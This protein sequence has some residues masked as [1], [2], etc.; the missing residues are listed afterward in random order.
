MVIGIV[1]KF[2]IFV[3]NPAKAD[4]T[5]KSKAELKAERR[6]KQEAQRA[7][8]A[9]PAAPEAKQSAAPKAAQAKRIPDQIQ[10]DR[11]SVE[12]RLVRK[13]VTQKVVNNYH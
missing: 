5:G 2:D 12:K 3:G 10:A 11:P 8:K 13:C 9:A 4:E 6:Q 1:F 7:A